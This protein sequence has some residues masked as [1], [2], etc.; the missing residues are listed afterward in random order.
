MALMGV[1][2]YGRHRGVSHV[3]VVKAIAAGRI[4]ATGTGR[5]RRIDSEQADREWDA[6]TDASRVAVHATA[7]AGTGPAQSAAAGQQAERGAVTDPPV[8]ISA[9]AIESAKKDTP[10]G[11]ADLV[12]AAA[13]DPAAGTAAA[14]KSEYQEHR[15]LRE[16]Y[17]GLKEQLEYEQLQGRL[18]DVNE[19][20]RLA[21]TVFRSLRD[22]TKNLSPRLKDQLAAETDP[23]KVEHLLDAEIDAVF[24]GVDVRKL[25]AEDDDDEA[26]G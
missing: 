12:D 10:A 19:A 11:A 9:A 22:A 2:E 3:A 14:P 25:F 7:P 18:V 5:E 6:N 24:A 15:T 8:S 21:F 4:S 13:Q 16:K 20:A 1:R 23:Y 26:Q 17:S